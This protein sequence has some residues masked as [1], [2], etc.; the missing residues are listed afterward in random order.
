M[1]QIKLMTGMLILGIFG[2]Q[3]IGL[4]TGGIGGG[5]K[6]PAS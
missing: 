3:V 2:D 4:N 5:V 6:G 1:N